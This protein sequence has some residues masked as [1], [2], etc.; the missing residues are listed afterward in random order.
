M[1]FF[2]GSTGWIWGVVPFFRGGNVFLLLLFF[3]WAGGGAGVG[4]ALRGRILRW[5]SFG[6]RG[7]VWDVVLLSALEN[8][9]FRFSSSFG[10][11][12]SLGVGTQLVLSLGDVFFFGVGRVGS[13]E[14]RKSSKGRDYET[15]HQTS[16][17]ADRDATK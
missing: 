11:R 2:F 5:C 6:S 15:I 16:N 14:G 17:S 8:I 4:A 13:G 9:V 12:G 1:I 10:W 7:W 3:L